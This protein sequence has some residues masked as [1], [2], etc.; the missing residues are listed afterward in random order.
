MDD[1]IEIWSKEIANKPFM[2][3][4]S[5]EKELERIMGAKKE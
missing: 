4:E 5:F 3:P 1:T 2:E